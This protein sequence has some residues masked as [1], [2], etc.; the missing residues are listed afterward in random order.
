MA[1]RPKKVI[2]ADNDYKIVSRSEDWKAKHGAWGRI[3]YDNSRIEIAPHNGD[4]T[5]LVDTVLH[6]ILHGIIHEFNIRLDK[7]MEERLV[8]SLANG[9]TDVCKS[10]PNLLEW[11]IARLKNESKDT[12]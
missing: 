4:N 9:L 10:N 7:R 3:D 2:I 8:T 1:R 5:A 12:L 11:V 6:E